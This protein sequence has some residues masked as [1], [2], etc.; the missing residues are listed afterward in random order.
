MYNIIF[1][2]LMSA[3]SRL[4]WAIFDKFFQLSS[5]SLYCNLLAHWHMPV[6][7]NFSFL[8]WHGE[9]FGH[10]PWWY[11]IWYVYISTTYYYMTVKGLNPGVISKVGWVWLWLYIVTV[12]PGLK[13][14]CPS[15]IGKQYYSLTTIPGLSFPLST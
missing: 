2:D 7:F 6:D 12:W 1:N 8:P 3:S 13:H 4:N 10:K 15:L 5:S 9:L 11:C 14:L